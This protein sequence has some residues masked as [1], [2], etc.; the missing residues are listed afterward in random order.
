VNCTEGLKT[1]Y[2]Y[3]LT[4]LNSASEFLHSQFQLAHQPHLKAPKL[5][6]YFIRRKNRLLVNFLC[7]NLNSTKDLPSF[8]AF[9]ADQRFTGYHFAPTSLLITGH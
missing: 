5:I 1:K 8:L 6:S 7:S 2:K 9:Q 3:Q 4:L